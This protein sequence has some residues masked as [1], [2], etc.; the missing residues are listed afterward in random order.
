M[1]R[2]L[3]PPAGGSDAGP[4]RLQILAQVQ[5]SRIPYCLV[6]WGVFKAGKM[7]DVPLFEEVCVGECR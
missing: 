2:L 5:S 7:G 6:V 1:E 4:L 3:F